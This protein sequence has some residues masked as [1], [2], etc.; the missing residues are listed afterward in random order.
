MRIFCTTYWILLVKILTPTPQ[1]LACTK[2]FARDFSLFTNTYYLFVERGKAHTQLEQCKLYHQSLDGSMFSFRDTLRIQS[3]AKLTKAFDVLCKEGNSIG[4][5]QKVCHRPR[6]EGGSSKIVTKCDK[7]RD[8]SS[9]RVMSPLQKN[10]V[11]T[12]ALE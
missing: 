8:R 2:C 5:I 1:P 6:G 11:L 9:Q 4:A 10:I 12:I 3:R 7:G